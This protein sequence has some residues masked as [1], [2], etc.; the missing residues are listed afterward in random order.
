MLRELHPT[1]RVT[2]I[3]VL[4]PELA[5]SAIAPSLE[6]PASGFPIDRTGLVPAQI[7][8][9]TEQGYI[10]LKFRRRTGNR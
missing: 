7:G 6:T 8:V 9:Q 10:P 2:E 1:R 4:D 5:Q 3:S